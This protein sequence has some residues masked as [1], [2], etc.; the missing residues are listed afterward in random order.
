MKETQHHKT[1]FVPQYAHIPNLE[2][3]IIYVLIVLHNV[4]LAMLKQTNVNIVNTAIMVHNVYPNVNK[5]NMLVFMKNSV[6]TVHMD[7][8]NVEKLVSVRNA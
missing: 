6:K 1:K 8:K 2:I 4:H 5:A 3:V 7:V